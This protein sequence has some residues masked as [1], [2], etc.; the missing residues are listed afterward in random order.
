MNTYNRRGFTLIELLVVIAIIGILVGLL[1]PAV[2]T[3]RESARRMQCSNNLKQIGIALH[4]YHDTFRRLPP[5]RWGGTGGKVWGPHSLILPF[6]EQSNVHST[7]DFGS[8]WSSPSNAAARASSISTYLCPS[9]PQSVMPRGWAGTNYHGCEGN[10]PI[11]ANGSFCHAGSMPIMKFSDIV[12]G[13]S[14]TAAFCERL[15][16][17]WSNALITERSDIF[18][19]GGSPQTA[20][21]A[22]A[23]CRAFTPSLSNQF[24][25]NSGAPWLAGTADNFTGYLH[26]APPGDRSCHFPPGSQMRTANSA[27]PGGVNLLRCDGSVNFSP[28]STDLAVWRALGSRN[29]GEVFNE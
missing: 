21:Q 23:A 18:A 22:M 14:N 10:N 12:D 29:E 19:P 5:G 1:L 15:K 4:S 3:A 6:L 8:L 7:I 13:L 25:S 24:Q 20:D 17:D 16:G 28:R 2:Q 26:I 9:D 11:Q 27:H